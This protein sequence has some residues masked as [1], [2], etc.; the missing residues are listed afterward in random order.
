MA[1]SMAELDRHAACIA[2]RRNPGVEWQKQ[3]S[4]KEPETRPEGHMAQPRA[5]LE[6]EAATQ[7]P[8]GCTPTQSI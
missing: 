2:P 7:P 4:I 1:I 5:E 6:V 3:N 8:A